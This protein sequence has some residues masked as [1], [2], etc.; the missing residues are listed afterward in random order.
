MF[1]CVN[2]VECVGFVRA[3]EK[4]KDIEIRLQSLVRLD[5]AIES[6]FYVQL[7]EYYNLLIKYLNLLGLRGRG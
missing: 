4:R 5:I 7:C 2:M 3:E 6:G 1:H